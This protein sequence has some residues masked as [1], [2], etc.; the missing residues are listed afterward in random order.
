[1][2]KKKTV[3]SALGP[4]IYG[5]SGLGRENNRHVSLAMKKSKALAGLMNK[6]AILPNQQAARTPNHSIKLDFGLGSG[7]RQSYNHQTSEG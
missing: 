1:M 6:S 2:K 7:Q 4:S 5:V 3:V